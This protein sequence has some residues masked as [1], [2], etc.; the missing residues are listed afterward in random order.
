MVQAASTTNTD[1]NSWKLDSAFLF[2]SEADRVSAGELILNAQK[3]FD[4]E[5]V[6]NIKLTVDT[7]TGA[8]A[9]GAV[10]QPSVQTFT[11]P[12]GNG[13]Y[14][15]SAGDI[16]LDDTFKDTRV[17][18]NGQWTQPLSPDYKVSG[19]FHLSKEYDYLSLGIKWQY[20]G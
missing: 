9:N 19:G 18:L 5:E 8:S 16:P 11:R 6:L 10:A 2:Y 17:Q 12:S 20:C 7:L 14:L 13:Q 3:T 15:I 1:D 4:S